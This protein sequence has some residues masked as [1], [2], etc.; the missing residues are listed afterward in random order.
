MFFREVAQ[1]ILSTCYLS[2]GSLHCTKAYLCAMMADWLQ[3]PFVYALY[4]S[5]GASAGHRRRLQTAG[6]VASRGFSRE[7]NATLFVAGFGSSAIFG[8]FVGSLADKY[9]R[10]NFAV[11]RLFFGSVRECQWGCRFGGN[12]F[13]VRRM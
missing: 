12:P 4:A 7:D 6:R 1:D 9:G 8:T 10:R 3:G 2:A 13:L 11:T 5:Y